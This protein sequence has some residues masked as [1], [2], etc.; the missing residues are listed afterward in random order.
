M[1]LQRL[2]EYTQ[3]LWRSP[4]LWF[5]I[6]VL[7]VPVLFVGVYLSDG[8]MAAVGGFSLASCWLGAAI[9]HWSLK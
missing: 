3:T 9:R 1:T 7:N 6:G 8:P 4:T 2:T 5:F